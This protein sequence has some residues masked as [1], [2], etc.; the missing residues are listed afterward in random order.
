MRL[1]AIVRG[2]QVR[3][4]AAVMLKCMQALVQAQARVRARR[5]HLSMEGQAMQKMLEEE[6]SSKEDDHMKQSEAR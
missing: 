1:Q 3:K 2:W 5:T 6:H 4:Q